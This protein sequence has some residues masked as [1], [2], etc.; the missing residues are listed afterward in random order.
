MSLNSHTIILPRREE[1]LI[2][3]VKFDSRGD[4]KEGMEML[5]KGITEWVKN[6]EDGQKAWVYSASDFNVG[7]LGSY[8]YKGSTIFPFLQD[9]GV[10]FLDLDII[11]TG[12]YASDYVYDTVL[13]DELQLDNEVPD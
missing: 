3:V 7:D 9:A 2:A 10:F 8:L 6:T 4:D 5:I 1:N 11:G 13:V 12:D